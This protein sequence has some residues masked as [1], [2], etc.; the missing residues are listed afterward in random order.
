[1]DIGK[2]DKI[3]DLGCG[4]GWTLVQLA[5]RGFKN[6]L[7]IDYAPKA[8]ELAK[9]V[10]NQSGIDISGVQVKVADILDDNHQL[11]GDIKLIHDKGTYDAISLS[12][13]AQNEKR[14]KYIV[15]VHKLLAQNGC[16]VI[17]SCNW[18]KD[19][20]TEQFNTGKYLPELN[21]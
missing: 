13:E 15:N 21:L 2:D 6:L 20:L 9:S 18:T 5:K 16:L 8:V 11:D 3:I 14:K 17:S 10:I 12:P 1:M 4:N 19:E 7:G